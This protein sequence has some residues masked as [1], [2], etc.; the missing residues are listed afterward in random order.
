M[1]RAARQREKLKA[2]LKAREDSKLLALN[3]V[4]GV[5]KDFWGREPV[6]SLVTELQFDPHTASPTAVDVFLE[7]LSVRVAE[8]LFQVYDASHP[9]PREDASRVVGQAP[10]QQL[11]CN[12][13]RIREHST[14]DLTKLR[15][16]AHRQ[17]S[18]AASYPPKPPSQA[19]NPY[20]FKEHL[21]REHLGNRAYQS[22][23]ADEIRF[24]EAFAALDA[25]QIDGCA[26]K[27]LPCS[28]GPEGLVTLP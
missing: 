10:L 19:F 2:Q 12:A 1:D 26:G 25:E 23:M 20:T 15:K 22:P 11:Y 28:T 4:S 9:E 24:Q 17:R 27:G 14:T 7:R 5:D 21:Q 8:M 6:K 13:C 18:G 3:A 16:Q